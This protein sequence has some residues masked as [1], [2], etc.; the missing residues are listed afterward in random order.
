MR[1]IVHAVTPDSVAHEMGLSDDNLARRLS[2]VDFTRQDAARIKAV[3]GLVDENIE[4]LTATFFEFLSV[5]PEAQG[6]VANGDLLA[7]ARLL[8]AEHLG[9]MVAGVYDRDYAVQRLKLALL[10][11][12]AHLNTP[13]FLGAF[14]T[15]LKNLGFIIMRRFKTASME[16]FEHYIAL[17]KIAFFDI[18]L[19]V[20]TL[21]LERVR[22]IRSRQQ[23]EL[24]S[25]E[26]QL[27]HAQKMEAVGRLAGGIAHDFN[28]IVS[29]IRGY[30]EE[31]LNTL[32]LDDPNRKLIEP[33]QLASQRAALLTRQL[34]AFSRKQVMQPK[35]L[36][37]NGVV[38][39][40]GE[41]LPRI[42][43]E[44]IELIASLKP[45]LD[46]VIMDPGQL[47]Q[48]IMNLVINARDAMP[49]GGKLTLETANVVLDEEYV[50]LHGE[51]R[52]GPHVML[53]V[54]DTGI[55]MDAAT[56][57]KI[58]EP[59][60]TTKEIGTGTGLG[61]STVYGIVKQSEGTVWV[62]SEVGVGT[63]FKV[64]L[65][66][67]EGAA[68]AEITPA[69]PATEPGHETILLVEDEKPLRELFARV[70]TNNGYRVLDASD[71][72][73]ALEICRQHPGKIHLL[74]TDIVMPKMNGTK[75]AEQ[76]VAIRPDIKVVYMSGYTDDAVVH[77]GILGPGT[78]FIEKPIGTA[79][80]L[81]KIH[82]FLA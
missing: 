20:D 74:L 44:H 56:Q 64:Y 78:A 58:F 22:G 42:L 5:Q 40:M 30:S 52:P 51:C 3:K 25:K 34:L 24:A 46:S 82:D 69:P 59:F 45:N 73:H 11:A 47:E 72:D 66:R 63:I 26:E 68:A 21:D 53:A 33:I 6:L 70:L 13:L 67:H 28:N 77:H 55:G 65:P 12:G 79:E 80:L 71:P 18:G 35:V 76:I 9:A 61:L 23:M 1:K 15:L 36:S 29:V 27:R 10:Y 54:A 62:Y 37:L 8:K 60:F 38:K 4:F 48:I 2:F 43:G 31:T 50:G 49:H 39:R 57:S 14:H 19:I 17:K 7:Q 81:K 41:M 32:P 16:G 75:L